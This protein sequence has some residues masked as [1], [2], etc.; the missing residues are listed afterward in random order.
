L[1]GFYSP[2]KPPRGKLKITLDNFNNN[3]YYYL[4]FCMILRKHSDKRDAILKVIQSTTEHPG[5]Q[6]V[7][8]K[9]KPLIPNLSLGT[10]YRNITFFRQEGQVVSVGVVNGEERFDGRV[11]PHPHL[12]C[13]RCGRVMDLPCP[14]IHITRAVS[15]IGGPLSQET[16]E[17]DNENPENSPRG[18][19]SAGFAVDYRKT[20]FY[21]LCEDCGGS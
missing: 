13:S 11:K 17:A 12:V 1:P 21:G 4:R 8:D 2:N 18:A 14:E 16:G 9:L 5:A 20:V 10:V 6:W 15:I 19:E 3:Y 7:Y